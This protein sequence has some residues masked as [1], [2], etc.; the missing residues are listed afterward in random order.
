MGKKLINAFIVGAAVGL[1]G[2]LLMVLTALIVPADFVT[3]VA[4]VIFGVIS[5]GAIASGAYLKIAAFGGEG[6]AIPLCG[7]MFGAAAARAEAQA[8]G[9]PAGKAIRKGFV[10]IITVVGI[11]FVICFILG[12]IT[13]NPGVTMAKEL[14]LP[15]QFL[16][17]AAFGGVIC[18]LT[19]LLACFKIPFPAVAVIMM[20]V[21]GGVLTWVGVVPA[22]N[23]WGAGG[24]TATAVGCGNG[25]Y[26]GGSLLALAA[27]LLNV[28]LVFMGALAGGAMM[29]KMPAP[30]QQQ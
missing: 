6:A 30:P 22:L 29:K 23:L 24:I 21:F 27:V 25:A 7:L 26:M 5:A 4:M 9:A 14:S 20:A 11:G 1:V 12:L 15:L 3:P 19:Q 16:C 17:A 8:K 2:H 28:V 13:K 18:A 10:S